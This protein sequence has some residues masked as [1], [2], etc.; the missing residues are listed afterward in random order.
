SLNRGKWLEP[1]IKGAVITPLKPSLPLRSIVIACPDTIDFN[2]PASS[3]YSSGKSSTRFA[4]LPYI[5][6][7]AKLLA[8]S[9]LGG[10]EL[11]RLWSGENVFV[12]IERNVDL[13]LPA[14]APYKNHIRSISTVG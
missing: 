9:F 11:I 2:A 1:K 4:I 3:I 6:D 7:A 13:P 14:L 5:S 10:T 8:A 12:S